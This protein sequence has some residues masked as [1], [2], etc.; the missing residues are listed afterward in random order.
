MLGGSGIKRS[1]KGSREWNVRS[2]VSLFFPPRPL[3]DHS[4]LSP[5]PFFSSPLPLLFCCSFLS[6]KMVF[7]RQVGQQLFRVPKTASDIGLTQSRRYLTSSRTRT[8]GTTTQP[9]STL[10]VHRSL[11]SSWHGYSAARRSF[12]VTA[13]AA[14][15]HITPPKPGEEYVHRPALCMRFVHAAC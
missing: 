11:Q 5:E 7:W 4:Q 10:A 8:I 6:H 1:G 15:G 13:Q 2:F 12:S 3:D 9:R 14:H